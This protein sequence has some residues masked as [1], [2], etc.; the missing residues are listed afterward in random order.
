VIRMGNIHNMPMRFVDEL[1]Q[2]SR[3][4]K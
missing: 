3:G 4:G 2:I 1:R